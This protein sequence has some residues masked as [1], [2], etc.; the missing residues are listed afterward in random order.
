M[1]NPGEFWAEGVQSWFHCNRRGGLEV[2][3]TQGNHL[4]EIDTRKQLEEHLPA[5]AELL[6]ESFR[7]NRWTYQPVAKR[8]TEPH[9]GGYDPANAP[10]FHWPAEVLEA[11][12]RIEAERA[13]KRKQQQRPA[14]K[15]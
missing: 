14:A 10:T 1:S 15:K 4:G 12:N 11:Y 3:D 5:L 13:E 2:V 6:D 9:L 8:L 7:H